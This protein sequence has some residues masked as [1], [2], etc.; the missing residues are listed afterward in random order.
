MALSILIDDD[1]IGKWHPLYDCVES[2][3]CKYE[4]IL[5]AVDSDLKR[6]GTLEQQ[7]FIRI[8]DWKAARVKGKISAEYDVYA[9]AFSQ[10][11]LIGDPLGRIGPLVALDG[12]GVPVASTIL[13][14]MDPIQIPINDIRTVEVLHYAGLLR[15]L[16]RDEKRFPA[17]RA[18]ILA[19]QSRFPNFSLRQID[20][21]LF[22]FH[23][24]EY[25]PRIKWVVA[26]VRT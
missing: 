3:Q 15:H 10:A 19:I 8:L 26:K 16:S 5:A 2:D 14:F 21:A 9:R 6:R 23:K 20:R 17:F 13:H 4:L 11:H 22:A 12:I 24:L 25:E 7:T 1:F 18:A